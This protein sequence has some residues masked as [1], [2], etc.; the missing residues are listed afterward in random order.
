MANFV[1]RA[2]PTHPSQLLREKARARGWSCSHLTDITILRDSKTSASTSSVDCVA[3]VS[4]PSMIF[5]RNGAN[6][7][8]LFDILR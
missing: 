7:S 2:F 4:K 5:G 1:S 3:M 8:V 6:I